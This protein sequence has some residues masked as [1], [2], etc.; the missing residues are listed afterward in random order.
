MVDIQIGIALPLKFCL[1]LFMAV[2][3][4]KICNHLLCITQIIIKIHEIFFY[5]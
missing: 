1:N 3:N 2:T 4:L 5:T